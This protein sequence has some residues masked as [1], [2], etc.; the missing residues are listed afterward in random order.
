MR[1]S[2]M[3]IAL[4]LDIVIIIS[5]AYALA[6]ERMH[7]SR[8]TTGLF[9]SY[10][11]SRRI[12]IWRV[13][14]SSHLYSILKPLGVLILSSS[15]SQVFVVVP[16]VFLTKI[17]TFFVLHSGIVKEFFHPEENRSSDPLIESLTA[18]WTALLCILI[19]V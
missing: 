15:D 3:K 2:F 18:T 6:K 13:A 17:L 19:K 10:V 4:K 11:S 7:E 9:V 1:S 8:Q 14:G 16:I 5:L 12:F